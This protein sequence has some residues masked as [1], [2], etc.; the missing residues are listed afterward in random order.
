MGSAIVGDDIYKDDPTIQEL[1]RKMAE[2]LGKEAALFTNSGSQAN[3][4]AMMT[5][6]REKGEAIIM[7][8]LAHILFYERG[9][10]GSMAGTMPYVIEN[11]ADGSIPVSKM[12]QATCIG[13]DEHIAAL[14]AIS[15]ESS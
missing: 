9:G 14:S 15:L 6:A 1:E 8:N 11:E 3:C 10:L 2:V 12:E 4:I 5:L 13:E 7:G